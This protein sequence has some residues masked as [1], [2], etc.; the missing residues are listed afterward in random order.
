[1][2]CPFKKN[3]C[4]FMSSSVIYLGYMVDSEGLQPLPDKVC[5]IVEASCIPN[6]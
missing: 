5:A 6:S 3:K 2:H 1:M 4:T